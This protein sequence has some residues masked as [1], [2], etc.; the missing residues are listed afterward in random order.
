M[1]K[2]KEQ[3]AALLKAAQAV[4][5]KAKAEN[6]NL[7]DEELA[8]LEAST[9]Q[10]KAL[11][12]EIENAEKGDAIVK[13]L[14]GNDGQHGGT[15]RGQHLKFDRLTDAAVAAIRQKG[16]TVGA[17]VIPI[18]VVNSDPIPGAVAHERP[19]RLTDVLP[20][21]KRDAAVYRFVRQ[22][23]IGSPGGAAVV[24]P[25]AEKPELNVGVE[26][27]DARLRVIA[28]VSGKIDTYLL[29]DAANLRTFVQGQMVEAIEAALE[30]ETLTGNGTGEHFTGLATVSGVQTQAFVTGKLETIQAG[31]T[32]LEQQGIAA[33]FVALAAAD[34]LAISGTRNASG[35]FDVGGPID[36]TARRVWGVPVVVVPGLTANTGWV[37]GEDSLQI[38]TDGQLAIKWDESQGFT[39][40]EVQARAETR[41]NLDVLRP[42]ALVKLTLNGA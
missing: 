21:V 22:S 31:L 35:L 23:V 17:N 26:G 12:V 28:V 5:D 38:S 36:A 1:H 40:N 30:T 42:H 13:A 14:F 4:I 9:A 39:T 15:G 11:N 10:I 16:L 37:V 24:A 33:G 20:V 7:T 18:P 34:W 2:L 29:E 25:K 19:P 27:V 32:K 41:A 3:R 6:R 8:G